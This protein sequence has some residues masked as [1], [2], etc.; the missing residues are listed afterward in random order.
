MIE[1]AAI[2]KAARRLARVRAAKTI[3]VIVAAGLA[4]DGFLIEPYRL[5]V[6]RH[7]VAARVHLRIAHLSDLHTHGFGTLERNVVARVE[8]ARPD[9]IVV[10]GDTIDDGKSEVAR[11]L[12]T[13]LH[14]PLGVWVV[15]GNWEN[16]K[17]APDTR[18]FYESVGAHFLVNGSVK[19]KEGLWISGFDDA[20]SGSPALEPTLAAIPPDAYKIGIFHAPEY[21]SVVAGKYDLA[22]AGHT[23]GGQVRVPLFGALW[24]PPGS[25]TFV[26]GWY[27]EAGTKMY[28]SRGIGTSV[29]PVRFLCPPEIAIFDLD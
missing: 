28:V 21:L 20:V 2:E 26:A 27:E 12:F 17:K 29:L 3:L 1:K 19:L 16:W 6:T 18:A 22:F 11:E 14:A 4:I 15:P 24:L 10:T 13:K 25:G 9:I 23:H 8:A 7:Q 5:E